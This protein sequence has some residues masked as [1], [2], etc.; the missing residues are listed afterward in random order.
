MCL[1]VRVCVCVY[2]CVWV[3]HPQVEVFSSAAVFSQA[4]RMCDACQQADGDER[5]VGGVEAACCRSGNRMSSHRFL[6]HVALGV[7]L[8]ATKTHLIQQ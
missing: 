2:L 3:C 8:P 4:D 1:Y 6:S 7:F 5:Q